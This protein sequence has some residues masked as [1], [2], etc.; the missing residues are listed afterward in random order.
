MPDPYREPI[1]EN[2]Q[3][4]VSPEKS[5]QS[6]E[7]KA[8]QSPETSA[9]KVEPLTQVSAP[10]AA[11]PR[12]FSKKTLIILVVGGIL[13]LIAV[14][15]IAIVFLNA[16]PKPTATPLINLPPTMLPVE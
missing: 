1:E 11:P 5:A 2:P 6:N 10:P 16:G 9:K 12:R 3:P 4:V 8:A 14:G 15:A 13:I 7:Q